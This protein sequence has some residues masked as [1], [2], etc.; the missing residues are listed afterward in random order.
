MVTEGV[1][2]ALGI[3]ALRA[4]IGLAGR[5]AP[6]TVGP[7][8]T[9][10][11]IPAGKAIFITATLI[12]GGLPILVLQRGDGWGAAALLLPFFALCVLAMP[13]PIAVHA[14]DGLSARRWYGKTTRIG[15]HEIARM[16]WTDEMQQTIILGTSGQKIVHTGFHAGRTEFRHQIASLLEATG[17]IH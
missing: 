9:Y 1:A 11:V 16:D 12:L 8:T 7:R 5:A 4:L 15:W 10:G 17:R 13:G 2:A 14:V 6:T 3:V